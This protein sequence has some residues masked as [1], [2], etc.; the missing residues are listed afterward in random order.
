MRKNFFVIL[1]FLFTQLSFAQNYRTINAG[2]TSHFI[3]LFSFAPGRT[4]INSISIDSVYIASGY[5][6]LFNFM[7]VDLLSGGSCFPAS[8]ST[9]IGNK[10]IQESSGNDYFLN[11]N[12]DSIC[13]QTQANLNDTWHLFEL[14]GGDYIQAKVISIANENFI[15]LTDSVKTLSLQ[16]KN[17]SEIIFQMT[18]IHSR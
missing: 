18:L 9:W 1:F 11:I 6:E 8:R 10:I 4:Y 2:I 17:S 15:G 5:D 13:I 12:S 16:A 3:S 7:S 14:S